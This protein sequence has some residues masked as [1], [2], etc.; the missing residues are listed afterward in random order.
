MR[1]IL[2]VF[3]G[4][5]L[6][7]MLPLQSYASVSSSSV[8]KF[9]GNEDSY[10]FELEGEM[11][12]LTLVTKNDVQTVYIEN[13]DGLETVSYD[14]GKDELRFND[15]L[16]DEE[17]MEELRGVASE[18][19]YGE[20]EDSNISEFGISSYKWDPNAY[21]WKLVKS[22][23]NS[24][25]ITVAT[26]LVVTG[27]ILLLP[28]GTGAIA[29]AVLTAKAI[30]VLA[31]AIVSA[32]GSN[33][34]KVFYYKFDTYYSPKGGYWNNKFVLSVYKD[35]KRTKLVKRVSHITRYGKKY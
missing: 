7:F 9:D 23:K 26:V 32:S 35:K 21:N 6:F 29:G 27:V 18:L 16:V 19:N 2:L 20:V 31:S 34:Q 25:N 15:E 12:T 11:Y 28:T 5:L 14:K 17:V 4:I 10:T 33:G 22:Y 1:K 30:A 13:E 3:S 8:P 24:L